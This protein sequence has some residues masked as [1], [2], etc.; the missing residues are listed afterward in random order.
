[1]DTFDLQRFVDAQAPVW[2]QARAELAAGEK[3]SHWM[4]FVFPQLAALGRSATA[5]RYGIGS[6]AEAAAYARHPL[7]GPRLVEGTQLVLAVR[8]RSLHQIFG[9]PDDLKF[10]SCVTLFHAVAPQEPAYAEVLE[11]LLHGRPDAA[12]LDW[13]AHHDPA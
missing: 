1:M 9:A 7:L 6:R 2:P 8:G 12:T 13:L 3:R 4:W 10:G 5:K 11:R